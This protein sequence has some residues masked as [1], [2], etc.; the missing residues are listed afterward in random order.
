MC[1]IKKKVR[2]LVDE[3]NTT[4]YEIQHRFDILKK[5]LMMLYLLLILWKDY[6]E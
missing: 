2:L 6:W 1:I 3:E 4:I 5:R